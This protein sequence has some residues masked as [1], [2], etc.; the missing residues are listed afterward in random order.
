MSEC[1]TG[2]YRHANMRLL[3]TVIL[4][5]LTACSNHQSTSESKA[6]THSLQSAK[7]I[8]SVSPLKTGNDLVDRIN[9]IK[10]LPQRTL[11]F[12]N[13][14]IDSISWVCGDS[15][16]WQIVR[17]GQEAIPYLIKKV[18]DSSATNIQVPCRETNLN[19]G[20]VALIALDH[21]ISIPYFMVFETQWDVLEMNCDFGQPLHLLEYINEHP[22]LASSK[23]A[24]WYET[25][26]QKIEKKTLKRAD[27][28]NCEKK[29]GIKYQL[30]IE[31]Q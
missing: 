3:A 14:E 9:E 1:I 11:R 20:T 5:I 2:V 31:Y 10:K 24:K 16:Y 26:G 15:L 12:K 6:K 29:H 23:L 25:Y 18:Q 27:Q 22:Q 30:T 8:S 4:S 13:G 28:S 7:T 19:V 21:I 17:L